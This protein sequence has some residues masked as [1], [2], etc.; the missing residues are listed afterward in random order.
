MLL[1]KLF[2]W[3]G[4]YTTAIIAQEVVVVTTFVTTVEVTTVKA[5]LT[6]PSPASYTSPTD[7][8]DTVLKVSNEYRDDHDAES[9][10]WNE[11]LTEYARKWAEG[12]IWKHSDGPY[13]EN[14]AFGFANAS[15]AVKAWGDEG[16]LYNFSKPTGYTEETGHFTQLVWKSTIQVGCAAVN[17][18]YSDDSNTK[19]DVL[20]P[21]STD[22]E[23]RAQGWYVVCEYTPVGNVVGDHD[24]YFKKNVLPSSSSNSTGSNTSTSTSGSSTASTTHSSNGCANIQPSMGRIRTMLLSLIIIGIGIG[25]YQ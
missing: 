1:S 20:A 9:L 11:T 7:F 17:C 24:A 22:S 25:I 16:E 6:V 10:V 21:R 13:G 8:E 2:I 19:R 14:I 12:C 18:G 15:A 4:I 23:S 5:S 3:I